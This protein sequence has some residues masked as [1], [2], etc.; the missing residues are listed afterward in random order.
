MKVTDTYRVRGGQPVGLVAPSNG[1]AV[2]MGIEVDLEEL[3]PKA[4]V[5]AMGI[6]VTGKAHLVIGAERQ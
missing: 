3:L 5:S 2:V 1:M 4:E 6:P